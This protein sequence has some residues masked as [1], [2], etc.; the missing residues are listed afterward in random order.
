MIF[1]SKMKR[2]G[3]FE[4]NQ[5]KIVTS[6]LEFSIK[7]LFSKFTPLDRQRRYLTW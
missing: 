5:R 7:L 3:L 1:K 6:N 2:E 4:T